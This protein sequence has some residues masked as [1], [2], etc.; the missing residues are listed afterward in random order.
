LQIW[1]PW[2]NFA[3]SIRLSISVWMLTRER[4]FSIK[5]TS[6]NFAILICWET[7]VPLQ[8][9]P[10]KHNGFAFMISPGT[11]H[12]LE[13]SWGVRFSSQ[14]LASKGGPYNPQNRRFSEIVKH[15]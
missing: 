6:C 8:K 12:F 5:Q 11:Q 2:C 13:K 15:D 14:L 7:A 9:V 3:S 1:V 10:G 4:R